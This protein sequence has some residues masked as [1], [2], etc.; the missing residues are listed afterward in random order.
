ML[1][2]LL[3]GLYI[4]FVVH[5][6]FSRHFL[7]LFFIVGYKHIK[8]I[9]AE[10]NGGLNTPGSVCVR[11]GKIYIADT[12]NSRILVLEDKSFKVIKEL[13]KPEVKLFDANYKYSPSRIAVDLADRIYV[14]ATDINDGILLLNENGKFIR[15]AAAPKVTTSLWNK[16]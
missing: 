8:E 13:K 14:I 16:F 10:E 6:E 5:I 3:V 11:D 7:A 12:G 4:P 15:F 2:T 1:N 9:K